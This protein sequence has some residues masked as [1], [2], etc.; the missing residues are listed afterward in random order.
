VSQQFTFIN[1]SLTAYGGAM[2]L[3]RGIS[4]PLKC[5]TY[6]SGQDVTNGTDV[7]GTKLQ[8]YTCQNG[9]VNQ[10]WYYTV[11]NHLAW[12]NH[13]SCMVC[14]LPSSRS[15]TNKLL[16]GLARRLISK[17]KSSPAMD[18]PEWSGSQSNLERWIFRLRSPYDIS[19]RTKWL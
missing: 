8:L 12:T 3:V 13:G 9:S 2:C 5:R 18:M 4:L 19:N 10:Q 17:R 15:T 11:D 14:Y 16:I 6:P 1:G 7:N